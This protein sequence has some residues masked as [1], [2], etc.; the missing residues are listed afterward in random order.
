MDIFDV[1]KNAAGYGTKTSPEAKR[2]AAVALALEIINTK[3]GSG[4]TANTAQLLS[5]LKEYA[6]LIEA[7]LKVK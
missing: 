7:A 2:A 6:D 1:V 4:A 3:A 5:N